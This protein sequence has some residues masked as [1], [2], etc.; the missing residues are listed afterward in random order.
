MNQ[1][2]EGLRAASLER[3]LQLKLFGC[4]GRLSVPYS[5]S[6][7]LVR[8]DDTAVAK[9][10]SASWTRVTPW[11]LVVLGNHQAVSHFRHLIPLAWG[12][13]GQCPL[14]RQARSVA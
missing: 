1:V 10:M 4:C 12:A 3:Q 7:S 8:N 2:H 6:A 9:D 14:R 11:G 5:S 13:C